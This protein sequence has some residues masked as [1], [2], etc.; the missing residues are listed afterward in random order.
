[1]FG[2]ETGSD[3]E[4]AFPLVS[5]LTFEPGPYR[6]CIRNLGPGTVFVGTVGEGPFSWPIEPDEDM[7]LDDLETVP[8]LAVKPFG[9]EATVVGYYQRVSK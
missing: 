5:E 4:V 8:N 9:Q 2:V 6:M 1:M 7:L 3:S